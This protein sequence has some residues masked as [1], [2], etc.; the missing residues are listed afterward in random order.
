MDRRAVRHQGPSVARRRAHPGD[1]AH[2]HRSGRDPHGAATPHG[3]GV[4][5]PDPPGPLGEPV[6][7]RCRSIGAVAV[8]QLRRCP[9]RPLPPSATRHASCGGCGPAR[10]W[11]TKVRPGGSPSCGWPNRP[12]CSRP[13]FCWPPSARRPSSSPADRFD[14]VILHPFLTPEAVA[15]FGRKG[16]R[17]G[18]SRRTRPGRAAVL[19]HRRG[20]PRPVARGHRSGRGGPG[21]RLLPRRRPRRRPGRRQRLEPGIA[22]TIPVATPRSWRSATSR[23]TRRCS[24]AQLIEVS[25]TLPAEWIPSSSATGNAAQLRRPSARI[26]RR[27]RRRAGAPRQHRRASR[28]SGDQLLGG[29]VTA[30]G[31]GPDGT[32][33]RLVGRAAAGATRS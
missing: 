31:R 9:R 32:V 23:P 15:A 11:N 13:R 14:G 1:P 18:R 24:R 33:G 8:A 30:P 16:P 20:R 19:R 29:P 17:R 28:P 10:R 27:R 21:R 5:G 12:M 25:R 4:D 22:G 3:A 7:A 6:L 2:S 26:S